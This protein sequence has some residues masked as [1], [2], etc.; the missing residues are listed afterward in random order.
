LEISP[1]LREEW[2]ERFVV[3][4]VKDYHLFNTFCVTWPFVVLSFSKTSSIYNTSSFKPSSFVVHVFNSFKVSYHLYSKGSPPKMMNMGIVACN[5]G[6][7][8]SKLG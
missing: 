3:P 1:R 5:L 7:Q 4:F 8:I 2:D 6:K